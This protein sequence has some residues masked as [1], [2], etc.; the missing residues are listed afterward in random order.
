[1]TVTLG[2]GSLPPRVE[3][4]RVRRGTHGRGATISLVRAG[5]QPDEYEKSNLSAVIVGGGIGGLAAAVALRRIGVDAH[6]YERASAMRGNAGTGIAIWPN[7]I[8]ALRFLGDDV[9]SEVAS[10]G[11]EITGMRMGMIDEP[12][13][14]SGEPSSDDGGIGGALK[15]AATRL[16][17]GAFPAI[18]RA[19]HGAGLICI[20]W[21]EAQAALASFL[22]AHCVHL[23]ASLDGIELVEYAD[24]TAKARCTFVKRDGTP[25][26]DPVTADF[27][28]GA[29]GINSAVRA[30]LID[31]G[32]PRDNGRVIW[33]GVVDAARVAR[34]HARATGGGTIGGGGN[35]M[36]AATASAAAAAAGTRRSS[37]ISSSTARSF[38]RASPRRLSRFSPWWFTAHCAWMRWTAAPS[39]LA[40]D[41]TQRPAACPGPPMQFFCPKSLPVVVL[42][43]LCA[44]LL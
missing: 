2:R 11:C 18:I 7:G 36:R 28:V 42:L 22:P 15:K 35:G 44:L 4:R 38:G 23:D 25:H 21:A 39:P 32:A 20:R 16:V 33:R 8:K 29:D 12:S 43:L 40:M 27:V 14:R 17:G 1:M 5:A 9:A 31:D 6:V 26:S 41:S 24:G 34:A 37:R 30:A 19:Q 3:D 10:R 13:A